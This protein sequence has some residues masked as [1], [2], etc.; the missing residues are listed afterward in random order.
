MVYCARS[1]ERKKGKRTHADQEWRRAD[2]DNPEGQL[3]VLLS[4]DLFFAQ[5]MLVVN[6]DLVRQDGI[7]RRQKLDVNCLA[8]RLC[9]KQ[10]TH[11]HQLW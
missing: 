7:G 11:T 1:T 6:F 5:H 10:E 8:I 4:L 2:G 9:S 3:V